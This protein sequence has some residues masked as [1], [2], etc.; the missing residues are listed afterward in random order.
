MLVL[1]SPTMV[2]RSFLSLL[3]SESDADSKLHHTV[4]SSPQR[5]TANGSSPLSGTDMNGGRSP[6]TSTVTSASVDTSCAAATTVSGLPEI[7]CPLHADRSAARA[8]VP[9]VA[10]I[11][12][13]MPS[14][15]SSRAPA[16]GR[17]TLCHNLVNA[18]QQS[19]CLV[20]RTVEQ[21]LIPPDYAL[22]HPCRSPQP[23]PSR[24]RL[25]SSKPHGVQP[26]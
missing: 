1:S 23:L 26:V 16:R 3:K 15:H 24:C 5:A 8:T 21:V 2:T 17:R 9:I 7:V 10:T 19:V 18:P 6:D 25:E 4:Q 12:S 22:C 20:V 13:L 11:L 14:L